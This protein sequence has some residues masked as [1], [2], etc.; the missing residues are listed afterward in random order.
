MRIKVSKIIL[1]ITIVFAILYI[2]PP[3]FKSASAEDNDYF[4]LNIREILSISITT[5][6]SWAEGDI[7]EF[8]RNKITVNV[9]SNNGNGF[10]AGMTTKTS[11]TDLKHVTK[12]TYSIP[13]ITSN[14][15]CNNSTCSN[16]P[17]NNWG[18]SLDNS[19]YEGILGSDHAPI[20][21][22]SSENS[23]SDSG[24]VYFGAKTNVDQS[25]G[26][27]T[28]AI[29]ITVVS[30]TSGADLPDP[31]GSEESHP[32]EPG[33]EN[34]AYYDSESDTT[35]YTY[36][37]DNGTTT[38]IV[39]EGDDTALYE[40]YTPP[41]GVVRSNSAN[42]YSGSLIATILATTASVAAGTG[43]LFFILAKRKKDEDED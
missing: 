1:A 18:Y 13:T 31:S 25:S 32:A 23:T 28:G 17:S 34:E 2:F 20:T 19:N 21:I 15:L 12:E 7:D 36:K 35:V 8:L 9:T 5:P 26:T 22:L 37:P 16:F 30:G 24:D 38:T 39:S 33:P 40:G 10:T 6:T 14:Y 3:F 27:Y 4:S 11:D 41:Q 42:I 29:V 43:I